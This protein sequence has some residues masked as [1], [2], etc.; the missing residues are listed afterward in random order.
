MEEDEGCRL[1]EYKGWERV[2]AQKSR[3]RPGYPCVPQPLFRV[4]DGLGAV[5][6]QRAGYGDSEDALT[7]RE[8]I[9]WLVFLC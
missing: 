5:G 9:P 3:R 8:F 6:S 1:S 7:L 2:G 4:L